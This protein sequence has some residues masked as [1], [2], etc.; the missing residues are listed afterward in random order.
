MAVLKMES[1]MEHH[2]AE[3]VPMPSIY[4]SQYNPDGTPAEGSAP[5]FHLFYQDGDG[6]WITSHTPRR[7]AG[8]LSADGGHDPARGGR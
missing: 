2:I 3:F 4:S 8:G 1:C 6:S 7:L 5:S